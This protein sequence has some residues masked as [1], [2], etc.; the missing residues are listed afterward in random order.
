MELSIDYTMPPRKLAY[1]RVPVAMEARVNQGLQEV[2][3]ADM[4]EP[5]IGPSD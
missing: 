3:D 1:L 4:I 2:L 5:V